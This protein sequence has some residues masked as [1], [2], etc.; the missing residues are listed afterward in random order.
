M[1]LVGQLEYFRSKIDGKLHP[2]AV[3]PTDTSDEP[4]SLIVE[5]SPG[6][7]GDLPSAVELTEQI[8]GIAAKH[9]QSCVVLNPTGRGSG[10]V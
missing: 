5:V 10:S 4:K 2:C 1:M 7:L 8:A 6:A 3:C 9:N